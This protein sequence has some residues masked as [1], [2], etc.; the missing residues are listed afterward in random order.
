MFTKDFSEDHFGE[1]GSGNDSG[2][3]SH[4]ARSSLA[5]I[6][7]SNDLSITQF[8]IDTLR[9][10]LA[11]FSIRPDNRLLI[12]TAATMRN[13]SNSLARKQCIWKDKPIGI[14]ADGCEVCGASAIWRLEETD[15]TIYVRQSWEGGLTCIVQFSVP[16][17]AYGVNYPGADQHALKRVLHLI[18][19]SKAVSKQAKGEF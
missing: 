19:A 10:S 13:R 1:P 5:K 14:N 7:P 2:D 9:L 15:V 3:V 17:L 8:G 6:S 4:T 16:R 11:D 18:E 12:R